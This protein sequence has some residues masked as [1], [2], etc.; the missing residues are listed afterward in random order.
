MEYC[1]IRLSPAETHA[2]DPLCMH[3]TLEGSSNVQHSL[4][5][6]KA[7]PSGFGKTCFTQAMPTG[8]GRCNAP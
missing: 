5:H 7:M 3:P 8:F 2:D 6:A 1:L 4:F